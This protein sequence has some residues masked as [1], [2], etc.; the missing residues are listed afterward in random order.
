[1][2]IKEAEV[3]QEALI[4]FVYGDRFV[5][6]LPKELRLHQINL[7]KPEINQLENERKRKRISNATLGIIEVKRQRKSSMGTM[8]SDRSSDKNVP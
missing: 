7:L 5:L 8:E 2:F 4:E 6:K 1:L 3:T